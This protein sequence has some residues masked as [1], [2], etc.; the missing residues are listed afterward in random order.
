MVIIKNMISRG[1]L[2]L[3]M[4]YENGSI[5]KSRV[6]DEPDIEIVN[7]YD[8]ENKLIYKGPYRNKIPVGVHREYGKDGKVINAYLYNDNGLLLSEGIVDE[9]GN[10]NGKW[11]DLYPDGKVQAEGTYTD[12]RRT[13][14]WK[15]YTQVPERLN[16]QV[17]ITTEDPMDYGNGIMKTDLFSGKKNIFRVRGM[18]PA[19]NIQTT[20]ILLHRESTQMV[21]EMS[22]GNSNQVILLKKENILSD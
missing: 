7:K 15:F 18:D 2:V 10:H 19:L 3:T 11:K 20:E 13:G 12:N 8:N 9:A 21:K 1:K 4:L 16:R 14:L 6:E 22:C 17:T 5:V